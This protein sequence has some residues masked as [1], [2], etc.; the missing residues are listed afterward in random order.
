M[1]YVLSYCIKIKWKICVNSSH[2]ITSCC[3]VLHTIKLRSFNCVFI[4]TEKNVQ[5]FSA[6]FPLAQSFV[7]HVELSTHLSITL[8]FSLSSKNV[9]SIDFER[10]KIFWVH[11]SVS[12]Y[13]QFF[14]FL[15]F[16]FFFL[17]CHFLWNEK[18]AFK[19][20]TVIT[21]ERKCESGRVQKKKWNEM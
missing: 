8:Q 5:S 16:F 6:C 2:W 19:V 18:L 21:P 7:S 20:Q 4:A 15:F 13:L 9:V 11:F 17:L 1:K 3:T 14:L 10:V 12:I